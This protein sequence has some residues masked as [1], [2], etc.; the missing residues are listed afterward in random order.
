MKTIDDVFLTRPVKEGGE[1]IKLAGID[2]DMMERQGNSYVNFFNLVTISVKPEGSTYEI[3]D[4]LLVHHFVSDQQVMDGYLLVYSEQIKGVKVTDHFSGDE[5]LRNFVP[6]GGYL[7]EPIDKHDTMSTH[8][9]ELWKETASV[10]FEGEMIEY[11]PASDY[12]LFYN[13]KMFFHVKTEDII[14]LDFEVQPGWV[15]VEVL[16]DMIISEDCLVVG[17]R[18]DVV[19][20][21]SGTYMNDEMIYGY[22]SLS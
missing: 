9:Q 16:E 5:Y 14:T 17:R 12:E 4:E 19:E 18:T 2:I 3:G 6:V 7:S 22:I 10:T 13:E 1:V 21:P 8:S 11:P 20:V 15:K